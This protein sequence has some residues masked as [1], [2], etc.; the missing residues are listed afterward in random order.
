[1]LACASYGALDAISLFQ[2][3][4]SNALEALTLSQTNKWKWNGME[5]MVW[6]DG[7]T[8]MQCNAKSMEEAMSGRDVM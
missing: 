3:I 2:N 6:M 4:P 7:M 1:V 8:C 5:W